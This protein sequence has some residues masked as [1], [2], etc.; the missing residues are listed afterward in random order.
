MTADRD[1][2][3]EIDALVD[4]QMANYDQRSGYD[5]NVNQAKCPQPWCKRDWHEPGV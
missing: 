1:V 2:V 4:W 3:D 5:K